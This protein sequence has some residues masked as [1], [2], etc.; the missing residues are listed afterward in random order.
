MIALT[1]TERKILPLV[2]DCQSNKEIAS[3]LLISERTVKFHMSN[4]LRKRGVKKRM[5][6]FRDETKPVLA[7][8]PDRF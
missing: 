2:L 4:I 6:L 1:K 3:R 7:S 8:C 5:E